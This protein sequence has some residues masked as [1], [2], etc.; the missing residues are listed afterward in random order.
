V[1]EAVEV[2]MLTI[3]SLLGESQLEELDPMPQNF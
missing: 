2:V 1:S 3:R